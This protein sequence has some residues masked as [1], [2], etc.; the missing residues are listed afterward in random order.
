[1][2]LQLPHPEY[3]PW[4]AGCFNGD[5]G[6]PK[7]LFGQMFEDPSVELEVF[8]P[9]SRIFCIASAGCTAIALATAGH[10]V[11]AIDINPVQVAYVNYRLAGGSVQEGSA[12]RLLKYGRQLFFVF[13]WKRSALQDFLSLADVD[14][15]ASFW[16][17][18]FDTV[19]W[20]FALDTMMRPRMLGHFY[21]SPFIRA[22]PA[23]FGKRV[24]SRM[25]RCWQK[26]PNR[27]NPYA[28]RLLLGTHPKRGIEFK[29][30]VSPSAVRN[31][32]HVECADAVSFL[33]SCEPG[34]FDGFSLSNILDGV[35]P[36]YRGKLMAAVKRAG[37]KDSI[38]IVRSFSELDSP[39]ES[40]WA[41]RDKSML[42]GRI[43]VTA[44][45]SL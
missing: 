26:H 39:E 22:L 28:W 4:Q 33:E 7:L 17:I 41:G 35:A 30:N 36:E 2:P 3:T 13:G 40:T 14:E 42:W 12:D 11:T 5:S 43:A 20:R 32:I 25:E 9:N 34:S 6:S 31:S 15:Q 19:T 29:E 44:I 27:S 8:S 16:K 18:H 37:T 23:D 1:M 45:H 24:R 10:Q 38:A 21:A